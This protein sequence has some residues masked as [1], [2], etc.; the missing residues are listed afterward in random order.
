VE[1]HADQA[2]P[3]AGTVLMCYSSRRQFLKK[4][5]EFSKRMKM[6]RAPE[7]LPSFLFWELFCIH[8]L[9]GLNCENPG[10]FSQFSVVVKT[11]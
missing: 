8:A 9:V 1:D 11:S 4:L 5:D 7:W 2:D 3:G 6:M 10:R